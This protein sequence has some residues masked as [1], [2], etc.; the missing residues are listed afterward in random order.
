MLV[1]TDGI[2]VL[3][4][5]GSY[6][7]GFESLSDLDALLLTHQHADHFDKDRILDLL[8]RNDRTTV[9]ADEQTA[10]LLAEAGRMVRTVHGETQSTT[11]GRSG[12]GSRSRC[13]RAPSG[14]PQL[15]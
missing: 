9:I 4:D 5:L 8:S 2:R 14:S 11:C 7:S 13:M 1:E 15:S 6:S 12:P 3:I 10:A